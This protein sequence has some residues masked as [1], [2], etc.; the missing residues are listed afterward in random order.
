MAENPRQFTS[1]DYA[2]ADMYGALTDK[3][4]TATPLNLPLENLSSKK[5]SGGISPG[6]AAHYRGE[7]ERRRSLFLEQKEAQAAREAALKEREIARNLALQQ[8]KP[9]ELEKPS[10]S[11]RDYEKNFQPSTSTPDQQPLPSTGAPPPTPDNTAAR[12]S[13]LVEPTATPTRATL[14]E[15]ISS[16]AGVGLLEALPRSLPQAAGRLVVPGVIAG[17]G[18][19]SRVVHGQ[20]IAQA[21]SGTAAALVGSVALEIVGTAVAGPIGG[22]IGGM[23]GGM[24]GGDIA[25]FIW[26]QTHPAGAEHLSTNIPNYPPFRGGQ[27]PGVQYKVTGSFDVVL[28]SP[29]GESL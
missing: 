17:I 20:S 3:P 14:K 21:A 28:Q 9:T 19:A 18:F 8:T 2:N 12:A 7:E 5:P 6:E 16:S 24:I 26:S 22:L 23:V 1:L 13:P 29:S 27:A 15:P 10:V 11:A 25:D 4:P